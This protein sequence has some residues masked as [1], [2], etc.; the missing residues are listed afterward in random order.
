[1]DKYDT[2][3]DL[4]EHPA[5]YRPEEIEVLLADPENRELYNLL[6]KTGSA[7][8]TDKG[9]SEIDIEAEWEAF[10]RRR[11][12]A[13][14][15]FPAIH[16]RAASITAIALSTLAAAAIGI[17]VAVKTFESKQQAEELTPAV[18]EDANALAALVSDTDSTSA[19]H[20]AAPILF[21]EE[22]LERI[23]NCIAATHGVT[24]EYMKPATAQLHLFYRFDPALP[25]EETVGQL[26]AFEQINLRIDGNKIIV[27]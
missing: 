25:L 4:I 13:G 2:V 10:Y 20:A 19:P 1:M 8:S 9:S 5:K 27:D 23:L 17:S 12:K 14:F 7:C 18:N 26:N 3:L 21:E 22:T 15:C 24:V 6:C 11:M 16:G